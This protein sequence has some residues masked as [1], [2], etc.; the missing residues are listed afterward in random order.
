MNLLA[1]LNAMGGGSVLFRDMPVATSGQY[2][3]FN[4]LGAGVLLMG[5]WALY[6]SNK[7]PLQ[8]ATIKKGLPLGILC[9][10]LT[11][12]ALSNQIT[13]GNMVLI[14]FQIELLN[15]LSVFRASGRFFWP[16]NYTLLFFIIYFI[17]VR[18]SPPKAFIYLSLGLAIQCFD[19]F[20]IYQGHAQVR[21]EPA[22]HWNSTLPIWNNYLKSNIWSIA[23]PYYRHITLVPPSFCGKAAAPYLPFSYLA[24]RYGMTINSGRTARRDN[25]QIGQYCQNLH[26]AIQQGK[27]TND[28]IY[29][30]HPNYLEDFKKAAQLPVVCIKID[31]FDTCVTEASFAQWQESDQALLTIEVQKNDFR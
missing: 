26:Q 13:L 3:G 31:G 19:L 2:E 8:R 6:E 28:A 29:V 1:P 23:A 14:D 9:I 27:V 4:Y 20:P 7:R 30:L 21:Q 11:L 18:N 16:V 15:V 5:A 25:E 24:G 10:G 12:F 17:V 22:K